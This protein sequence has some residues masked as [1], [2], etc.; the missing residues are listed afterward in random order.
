MVGISPKPIRLDNPSMVITTDAS[1]Q[2]WGAHV[3]ASAEEADAH[4]NGLELRAV[5]LGLQSLVKEVEIHVQIFTDSTTTQ[6][7]IRKMK[8]TRSPP[9]NEMAKKIGPG[10]RK[11]GTGL[12][13]PSSRA[14]L[15]S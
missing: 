12:Q 5:L 3:G 13:W 14:V 2:G 10:Q 9:C 4:I 11:E 15:M 6:A 1:L 8:G 7:Y